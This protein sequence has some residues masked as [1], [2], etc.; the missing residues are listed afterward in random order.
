MLPEALKEALRTAAG[1]RG[2]PMRTVVIS[3]LKEHLNLDNSYRVTSFNARPH[4]TFEN[5][6]KGK[7]RH[8][9]IKRMGISH[10]LESD[11]DE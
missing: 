3:A 10:K 2:V 1:E 7:L 4:T 5:R 11:S 9:V 6:M 8:H